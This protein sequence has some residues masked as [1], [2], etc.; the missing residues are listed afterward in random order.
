VAVKVNKSGA[1]DIAPGRQYIILS[2]RRG[3][4]LPT[5]PRDFILGD[6]QTA[7]LIYPLARVDYPTAMNK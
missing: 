2:V 1:N 5:Q 3:F 6:K 4:I 7:D